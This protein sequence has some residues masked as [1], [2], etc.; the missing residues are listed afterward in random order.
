MKQFP[1]M[2]AL[3]AL[4]LAATACSTIQVAGSTAPLTAEALK[5]AA[6]QAELAPGGKAQLTNGSFRQPIAPG[7]AS[8]LVITLTDKITSGDLNGDGAPDAAVILTTDAGGSGSF[9]YLAAV[10]N[11]QGKPNNVAVTLLGD[12][13]QLN[14]LTIND[15]TISVDMV[16][17]GPNDPMCCPSQKVTKKFKLQGTKLNEAS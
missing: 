16:T 17:Q 8:E 10:L 3:L 1:K 4:V 2:L 15:G 6:Y 9:Y 14:S 5:N 7:S 11:D 12:R 13:V